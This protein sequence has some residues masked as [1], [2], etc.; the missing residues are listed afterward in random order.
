M[1][2]INVLPLL[3]ITSTCLAQ[4][5]T[6]S[7]LDTLLVKAKAGNQWAMLAL[8]SVYGDDVHADT[9]PDF[10]LPAAERGLW[11]LAIK[12]ADERKHEFSGESMAQWLLKAAET[13]NLLGL[14]EASNLYE[15]GQF[16]VTKDTKRAVEMLK[17]AAERGSYVSAACLAQRYEDGSCGLTKDQAE[18]KRY[19]AMALPILNH[20]VEAGDNRAK[21]WL[22][23]FYRDGVGGVEK[24]GHKANE[25][26]RAAAQ[27]GNATAMSSWGRV[28][29]LG[30]D[31][32]PRDT[33]EAVIW[34]RKA[35]AHGSPSGMYRLAT[36]IRTGKLPDENPAD[37]IKWMKHS[38]ERGY[39]LAM[40]DLA[41]I[42]RTGDPWLPQNLDRAKQW[43]NRAADAD[44]D[45]AM[46]EL[47]M[48]AFTARPPDYPTAIEWFTK[49]AALGNTDSM[50][51]LASRYRHGGAGLP[52]DATKAV[53]LYKQAADADNT[54]AMVELAMCYRDGIGGLAKNPAKAN[55]LLRAAAAKG[56]ARAKALLKGDS[57]R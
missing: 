16:G 50:M 37:G 39:I 42:Y 29:L 19:Y 45:F 27:G 40:H 26:L 3:A 47:G 10:E 11:D 34:I 21:F 35:I 28:L 30:S 13:G 44:W 38:A 49:A 25:L 31:G 32:Q 23:R 17:T 48:I 53:E 14:D 18:A 6:P 2:L 24:D 54:E 55:E 36:L 41:D 56:S 9:P 15:T 46:H 5:A 57:R 22:S 12:A 1:R 52:A 51:M 43:Y 8:A 4:P 33:T 20:R 7:A